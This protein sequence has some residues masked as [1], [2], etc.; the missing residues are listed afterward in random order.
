MKSF[1]LIFLLVYSLLSVGMTVMIH[2]CGGESEALLATTSAEDPCGCSDE[3]PAD[4]CCTTELTTLQLNDAQILP[5]ATTLFSLTV[6]EILPVNVV[7][8]GWTSD[9]Q[10]MIPFFTADSSPPDDDLCIVNSVFL[11]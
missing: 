2:T 4:R 1:S 7:T 10:V 9:A 5:A 8:E 6:C 3:S 11:I